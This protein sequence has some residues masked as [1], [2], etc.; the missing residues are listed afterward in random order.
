MTRGW[1]GE[2]VKLGAGVWGRWSLSAELELKCS[3][4]HW[5]L[6]TRHFPST[7]HVPTL[8]DAKTLLRCAVNPLTKIA[9]RETAEK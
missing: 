8:E 2:K 3:T 6:L 5:F 9:R 4:A 7:A 1:G